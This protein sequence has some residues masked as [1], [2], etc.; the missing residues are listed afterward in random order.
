M[1]FHNFSSKCRCVFNF[2]PRPHCLGEKSLQCHWISGWTV[3]EAVWFGQKISWLTGNRIL[4]CNIVVLSE[5]AQRYVC[6]CVVKFQI[7]GFNFVSVKPR[8]PA[9][10]MRQLAILFAFKRPDRVVRAAICKLLLLCRFEAGCPPPTS[11]RFGPFRPIHA[12]VFHTSR[13]FPSGQYRISGCLLSLL[14]RKLFN[15]ALCRRNG[16]TSV[17]VQWP[18]FPTMKSANSTKKKNQI[19]NVPDLTGCCNKM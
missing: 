8:Y 17:R 3:R 18:T 1:R 19:A 10:V 16:Y 14:F 4:A 5:I 2:N 7:S 6:V 15:E 11:S 13:P 9:D 12:S